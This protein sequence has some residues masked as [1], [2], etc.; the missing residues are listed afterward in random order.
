MNKK[1][2]YIENTCTNPYFNLA[3]EEYLLTSKPGMDFVTLWQNENTVVI[4]NN[5]NA[6]EEINSQF[7]SDNSISVV[8]RTTGG[9]AVYHDLGNLNFSF[10]TDLDEK[11]GHTIN[12]FV[13]PVISALAEMGVMAEANG[14]NDIT[15]D[16]QKISGNAQRIYKNRILHHGTLL[17]NS[18]VKKISGALN[19][20]PEKFESKSTK[21]VESRIT[22]ISKYLTNGTSIKEF[23]K[24]LLT[25]FFNNSNIDQY[26]LTKEDIIAV[27]ELANTKYA[28][29]K[30][31]FRSAQPMDMHTFARFDGGFIEIRLKI[32]S[33]KI[34]ACQI[35][36]DFMSVTDVDLLE[37]TLVGTE[38]SP[39]A[40]KSAIV[41]FPLKDILGEITADEIIECIFK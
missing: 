35:N 14:R 2:Y 25:A 29:P 37:N 39:D 18:D 13:K 40:I 30:W 41:A 8:R 12:D 4:G 32:T 11:D 20:R 27:N 38:F 23:K 33:D 34:T 6:Y 16:G 24:N 5:Q 21:S 22:N 17:Y 15:I 1:L 19:V 7:V 26:L 28:D 31:T 10:I 3:L 36:G 9:G